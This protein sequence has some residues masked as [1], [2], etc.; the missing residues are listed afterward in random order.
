MELKK[1]VKLGITGSI[2]S[3]KTTIL[4]MF[5]NRGIK[6]WSADSSVHKLYKKGCLGYLLLA[7]KLPEILNTDKV[8]RRILKQS[9][10]EKK[11]TLCEIEKIIHPL[12]KNDRT[13]FYKKNIDEPLLVFEIPLLF[14]TNSKLEFDKIL[15]ISCSYAIQKERVLNRGNITESDFKFLL[16]KQ[17]SP[18]QKISQADYH[19]DTSY[20]LNK[21]RADVNKLLEF[22][23][24]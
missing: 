8:D 7:E 3:G 5:K 17:M 19:I 13:L 18:E 23:L 14:E 12:V 1:H 15:V 4:S 22:L 11:I 9:I 21:T 24:K 20:G 2:G 10:K 6:C 16:G